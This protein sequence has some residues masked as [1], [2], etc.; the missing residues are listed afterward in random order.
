[1]QRL[2]TDLEDICL[3]RLNSETPRTEERAAVRLRF[4]RSFE[5]TLLRKHAYSEKLK[6]E[7]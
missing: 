3:L 1:M 5:R 6:L 2:Q 7:F 4:R